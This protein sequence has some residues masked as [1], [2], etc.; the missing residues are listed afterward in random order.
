M[1]WRPPQR[2]I[3]WESKRR[4]NTSEKH[5]SRSISALV[6]MPTCPSSP[7]TYKPD[8]CGGQGPFK[9]PRGSGQAAGG[10]VT[11]FLPAS[12]RVRAPTLQIVLW[13]TQVHLM[14]HLSIR[15]SHD[16][17]CTRLAAALVGTGAAGTSQHGGSCNKK[18]ISSRP[19]R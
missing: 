7:L 19:S 2:S 10:T 3:E 14:T 18:V 8:K 6:S 12:V 5:I 16:H 1:R 13:P 4:R 17:G 11:G 9:Q 15:C